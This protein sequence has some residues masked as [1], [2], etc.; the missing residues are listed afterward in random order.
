LVCIPAALVALQASVLPSEFADLHHPQQNP[1]SQREL[2]LHVLMP[3]LEV[4]AV[5]E[6]ILCARLSL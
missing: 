3:N 2:I 6:E 4:M 5:V 1:L